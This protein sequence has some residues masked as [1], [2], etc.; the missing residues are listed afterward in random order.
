MTQSL[1]HTLGR[2][3]QREAL[4]AVGEFSAALAHEVRNPL[5]SVR[6]DL[7]RARERIDDHGANDLLGR[8]LEQID[9][10][11]ATVGGSLRMARS[12]SLEFSSVDLRRVIEQAM[13][14]ARPAFEIRGAVLEDWM[15]PAETLTVRGNAAALE[16]LLLNLLLN[17]A[18][19]SEMATQ[20]RIAV[21]SDGV[22]VQITVSDH[23]R[24]ITRD[25]LERVFEPFFSTKE[26]GTGL[27]LPVARR[28]A[29]AHGG[30]LSVD[31]AVGVGTS[32]VV[33]IPRDLGSVRD[34]RNETE[35]DRSTS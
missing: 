30:E 26:N 7:E 34:A 9:R 10:L 5:T 15:P 23:G 2:L 14:A 16:Q 17:S 20:T 19:A 33:T 4:A 1:T 27:G 21:R 13:R 24:G 28:I 11:D 25:R 22:S 35:R 32:V 29:R 12:G 3:S 31:S 6:L 18:E 8:A